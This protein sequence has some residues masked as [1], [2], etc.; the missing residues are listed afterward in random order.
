[1]AIDYAGNVYFTG[2]TMSGEGLAI[3]PGVFQSTFAGRTDAFITKIRAG[4]VNVSAASFFDGEQASE[5]IAAAFGINLAFAAQSAPSIPLPTLLD[6]TTVRIRDSAG[7]ERLAPLYFVSLSQI[8]YQ[9]PPGVSSGPATVVVT[10]KF[11][12]AYVGGLRI[13]KVAPGVFAANGNG[14]GVAAAVVQRVKADGSQTY[15]MIARFDQSLK[16]FVPIPIDLGPESDR[17][18][19]AIFGTGWRFR[20]S[21][22]AV[23]VTVGGV[24]VPVTYAGLQPTL[25]GLDQINAQLPRTLAGRGEVEVVATVDGK[26][27]NTVRVNIK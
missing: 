2:S 20:S 16:Q 14:Q 5:A 25:I 12:D 21:E 3:T 15:E 18:F 27:A 22:A 9:I 10:N 17:V 19:L 11:G 8:N 13:A 4:V 23:K 24:D 7:A 26:T 6:G 1:V